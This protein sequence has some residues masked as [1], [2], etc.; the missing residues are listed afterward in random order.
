MAVSATHHIVHVTIRIDVA[1]LHRD[2]DLSLP[3]SS[4]LYELIPEIAR[5]VELPQLHRPWAFTNVAGIPLDG[6]AP[7]YQL[8]MRNGA[9]VVMRPQEQAAPPVIRDAAHSLSA[10]A[11]SARDVRGLHI[12]AT[13][14]GLLCIAAV[15]GTVGGVAFGAGLAAAAA[16]VLSLAARSSAVYVAFLCTAPFAVGTWVAGPPATWDGSSDT[17]IGMLAAAITAVSCVVIG[18]ML[19]LC[20]AAVATFAA[21]CALLLA[22]ASLGAWLPQHHAGAAVVV[23]LGLLLVMLTPHIAT[24]AAGL[25]VPRI[26]TA[27]EEF[28]R[29]DV[30]QHDVDTRSLTALTVSAAIACAVTTCC[31]PALYGIATMD[32]ALGWRVALAGCMAGAL[33]IH[34][35]RHHYP[36]PRIALTALALG[37]LGAV[38]LATVY[39]PSPH[40]AFLVAAGCIAI[41]CATAVIWSRR[42]PDL[43]PTTVV[44]FERAEAAAIIAVIP[45]AVHLTGLFDLIRGL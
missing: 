32:A 40:P 42:V 16:L 29:S 23:L 31:L 37:A 4:S 15:A 9:T 20:G 7:L 14:L 12:G 1:S 41:V 35:V 33:L 21:V 13:M 24:A 3:T 22:A 38:V 44:W 10:A 36:T 6:H 8:K 26:P 30:Y 34:A 11:A 17:A 18:A 2:I 43:E 27:G 45:L 25:K 39:E 19:R 5:F 28:D